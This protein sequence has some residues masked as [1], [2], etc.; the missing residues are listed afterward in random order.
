[1][2][3]KTFCSKMFVLKKDF[4]Q[5]ILAASMLLKHFACDMESIKQSNQIKGGNYFFL[6][7]FVGNACLVGVCHISY[8]NV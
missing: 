8:V 4:W 2:S 3:N 7:T 5:N 6:S 1:M